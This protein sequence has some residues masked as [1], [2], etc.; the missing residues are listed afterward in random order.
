MYYLDL[1]SYSEAEL[2]ELKYDAPILDAQGVDTGQTQLTQLERPHRGTLRALLGYAYLRQN[3]HRNPITPINCMNIDLQAFF[4]YQCSG[5]FIVFNNSSFPQPLVSKP[6]HRKP[7]DSSPDTLLPTQM[8]TNPDSHLATVR[9]E[10]A[11]KH[12]E[13][14]QP[15]SDKSDRQ[16]T[17]DVISNQ[18]SDTISPTT[19][20]SSALQPS[21][22]TSDGA[23]ILNGSRATQLVGAQSTISRPTLNKRDIANDV[24]FDSNLEWDQTLLDSNIDKLDEQGKGERPFDRVGIL[25]NSKTILTLNEA[26]EDETLDQLDDFDTATDLNDTSIGNATLVSNLDWDQTLLDP[27]SGDLVCSVSA[28]STSHGLLLQLPDASMGSDS[29]ALLPEQDET[30]EYPMDLENGEQQC[31]TSRSIH[32]VQRTNEHFKIVVDDKSPKVGGRQRLTTPDSFV[33]P[34]DISNGLPYLRM[35]SPTDRELSNPDIPHVVLTSDT[36]WEP[37]VLDHLIDNMEEWAKSVPDH[38]PGDEEHLFDLVGVLKN[39]Y[40]LRILN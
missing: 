10:F 26:S 5:D 21:I 24:I 27:R 9:N 2:L 37:S 13:L 3:V 11:P 7:L 22:R 19:I 18:Y 16:A 29:D 36:D 28:D 4:N 1:L 40:L 33:L 30:D 6:D 32:S 38:D 35:R 14:Q 17:V 31:V 39:N 25:K 12:G 20:V 15:M 34:L 23:N 8:E